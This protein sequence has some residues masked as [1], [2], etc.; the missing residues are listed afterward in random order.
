MKEDCPYCRGHVVYDCQDL[1]Q[2][3]YLTGKQEKAFQYDDCNKPIF[4]YPCRITSNRKHDIA[5]VDT[6]FYTGR[7]RIVILDHDRCSIN[8]YIF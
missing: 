4:T 7:G 5:V 2:Q 6:L 1:L 3:S 8:L